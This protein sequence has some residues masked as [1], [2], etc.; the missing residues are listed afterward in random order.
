MAAFMPGASPPEVT[1]PIVFAI[2]NIA[3]HHFQGY[4]VIKTFSYWHVERVC[5]KKHKCRVI[6]FMIPFCVGR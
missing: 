4:M 5:A 1:I 6:V 2:N 3:P